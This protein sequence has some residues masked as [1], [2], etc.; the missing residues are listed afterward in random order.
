MIVDFV[1][2]NYWTNNIGSLAKDGRMVMLG[3]LSGAEVPKFSLAP[4]LYKRL[5][6]EGTTLRS[7]TLEYQSKLLQEFAEKA[8]EKVFGGCGGEKTGMELVIH[9]VSDG[10]NGWHAGGADGF[11]GQVYDWKDIKDAHEE[12]ESAK[13][14]VS[15]CAVLLDCPG[16][17]RQ[18]LTVTRC[19]S[20]ARRARSSARSSEPGLPKTH[21]CIAY[22]S[23]SPQ[24]TD[25]QVRD[26]RSPPKRF[27]NGTQTERLREEAKQGSRRE[28]RSD[29]TRV[30]TDTDTDAQKPK[31]KGKL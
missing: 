4:I 22:I 28:T 23:D 26:G 13:N 18:M 2:A 7:R 1:G 9:K 8:L 15:A 29:A 19:A 21:K 30:G 6:I 11:C 27:G 25:P 10:F 12:M 24:M 14:T 3:L 17:S 5:R 31:H 16:R 20:S